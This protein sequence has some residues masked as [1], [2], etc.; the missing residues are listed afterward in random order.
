MPKPSNSLNILI[1]WLPSLLG[2]CLCSA[3]QILSVSCSSFSCNPLMFCWKL[4][5]M[6]LKYG[7]RESSI[8][9]RINRSLC[10]GA[11]TFI[12]VSPLVKVSFPCPLFSSLAAAFTVFF[13]EALVPV[14]IPHRLHRKIRESC[15]WDEL[16]S[17]CWDNA[18]ELSSGNVLSL[19]ARPLL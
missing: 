3:P 7:K 11:V 12:R 5:V 4:V 19:D 15:S 2:V 13:L 8:L 14:I 10:F 1:F 17:L 6:V 16:S 9:F 18:L